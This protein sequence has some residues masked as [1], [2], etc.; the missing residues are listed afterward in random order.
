MQGWGGW[1][2]QLGNV[3][4][5]GLLRD[6]SCSFSY[7][8][9]NHTSAMCYSPEVSSDISPVPAGGQQDTGTAC[10][11]CTHWEPLCPFCQACWA[12]S[13][14]REWR[15]MRY[16]LCRWAKLYLGITNHLQV[17]TDLF[18]CSVAASGLHRCVCSASVCV[19]RDTG[20]AHTRRWC[21]SRHWHVS[22]SYTPSEHRLE[23]SESC[24]CSIQN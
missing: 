23:P 2:R 4:S 9:R 18:F 15:S 14:R 8:H 21:S 20:C 6:L 22:C 5:A 7:G 10:T 13:Q 12:P 24:L 1:W 19:G 3:V 16:L 17:Q 11:L